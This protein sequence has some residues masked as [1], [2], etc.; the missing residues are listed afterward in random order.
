MVLTMIFVVPSDTLV[1]QPLNNI[2]ANDAPNQD[3]Y[4]RDK[5][6]MIALKYI[7]KVFFKSK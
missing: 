1:Q 6:S 3:V 4:Y 2:L 5:I 7:Q